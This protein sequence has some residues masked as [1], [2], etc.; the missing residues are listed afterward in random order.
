MEPF[1]TIKHTVNAAE[2]GLPASTKI[3][4]D[5]YG[6]TL[7]DNENEIG[8][9]GSKTAGDADA[10]LGNNAATATGNAAP[11]ISQIP[12]QASPD[13]GPTPLVSFAPPILGD[14]ELLYIA[15]DVL[16]CNDRPCTSMPLSERLKLLQKVVPLE[17][18]GVRIPGD[19]GVCA[20]VIPMVPGET[21]LGGVLASREA[22]TMEEIENAIQGAKTRREDGIIIKALDAP[23]K[24]NDRS[25]SWIKFKPD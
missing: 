4:I 17:G 12:L 14:V 16:Y 9:G 13:S 7:A 15:F 20:R 8:E 19:S 23:W 18:S 2:K 10:D 11:A 21:Y 6:G 3:S 5:E 24:A 25:D 1:G 22:S